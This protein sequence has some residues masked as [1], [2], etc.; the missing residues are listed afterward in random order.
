MDLLDFYR[1]SNA[2]NI[3]KPTCCLLSAPPSLGGKVKVIIPRNRSWGI[4]RHSAMTLWYFFLCHP[5]PC[6]CV[7]FFRQGQQIN[8]LVQVPATWVR[9]AASF[10]VQTYMYI[11]IHKREGVRQFLSGSQ[12]KAL[13]WW[14][15]YLRKA[16]KSIAPRRGREERGWGGLHFLLSAISHCHPLLLP[17]PSI[18]LQ[19]A[20][21]ARKRVSLMV[22]HLRVLGRAVRALA[23]NAETHSAGPF[24]PRFLPARQEQGS[25]ISLA[26]Q[27]LR[28]AYQAALF[29]G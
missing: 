2:K 21:R 4:F 15:S 28:G 20:P 7:F 8:P 19:T 26:Y 23:G 11:Y 24:P 14:N 17:L 18:M 12:K 5:Q 22:R 16:P 13:S 29:R 6:N 3:R 9:K 27:R 1:H 10:Y 25:H